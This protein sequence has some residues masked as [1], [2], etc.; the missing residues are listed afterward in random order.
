MVL[1]ILGYGEYKKSLVKNNQTETASTTLNQMTDNQPA[2]SS[3]PASAT[4]KT[5]ATKSSGASSSAKTQATTTTQSAGGSSTSGQTGDSQTTSQPGFYQ[6]NT[7]HYSISYPTDWPIRIR[8]EAEVAI[9]TVPPKNGQ[10]AITIEVSNQSSNE[11]E[12]SKQEAQKYPG[13]IQYRE[14]K[15]TLAG[16]TGDKITM[17]NTLAKITDIYIILE[18]NN[19]YYYLKYTEESSD[20]LKEVNDCLKTL[21]FL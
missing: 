21:K 10:G 19:L 14:E 6:N 9:G 17:T 7:Y 20:F 5:A 1:A 2:T 11:L 16:V 15:I 13:I 8:S 12:Q 3:Q 4:A 18:K